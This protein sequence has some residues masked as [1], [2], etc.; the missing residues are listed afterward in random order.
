MTKSGISGRKDN[1]SSHRGRSSEGLR[2]RTPRVARKKEP[3]VPH[4]GACP[5]GN[6]KSGFENEEDRRHSAKFGYDQFPR[7]TPPREVPKS[8]AAARFPERTLA[9]VLA[10]RSARR[11]AAISSP[12]DQA[13]KSSWRYSMNRPTL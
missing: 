10:R 1:N 2:G 13:S 3:G 4:Q 5:P 8:E 11:E 7:F 9:A 12:P 6:G